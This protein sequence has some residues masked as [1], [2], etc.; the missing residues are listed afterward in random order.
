MKHKQGLKR[1]TEA[2]VKYEKKPKDDKKL[3]KAT[4]STK[5]TG[6][7]EVGHLVI[8]ETFE[9]EEKVRREPSVGRI[10]NIQVDEKPRGSARFPSQPEIGTFLVKTGTKDEKVRKTC[11]TTSCCL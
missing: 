8:D 6:R 7:A 10:E 2:I 4:K 3:T 5:F 9:P 1:K 11:F